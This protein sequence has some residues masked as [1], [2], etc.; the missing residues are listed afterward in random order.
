MEFYDRKSFSAKIE[1]LVKEK[2]MEYI[3]AIVWFCDENS[4]DIESA[5]S[6]INRPLKEKLRKEGED[7]HLLERGGKLPV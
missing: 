7:L 6:L 3:E 5:S 2:G 1:E 4:I